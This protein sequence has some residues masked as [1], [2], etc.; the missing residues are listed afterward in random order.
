MAELQ[1]QL[2]RIDL[3]GGLD[4]KSDER[5]VLATKLLGLQNASF[6]KNGSLQRRDGWGN[7][8]PTL[9]TGPA[10]D[11]IAYNNELL[12]VDGAANLQSYSPNGQ[13]WLSRGALSPCSIKKDEI[14]RSTGYQNYIDSATGAGYTIFA[15]QD[16]TAAGSVTGVNVS[17]RDETSGTLVVNNQQVYAS[18]TAYAP[19]VCYANG[20]F[21]IMCADGGVIHGVINQ[22]GTTTFS[23]SSIVGS[24]NSTYPHYDVCVVDNWIAIV[25]ASSTYGVGLWVWDPTS[26]AV[27]LG[28]V[29]VVASGTIAASSITCIGVGEFSDGTHVG[30]V[31]GQGGGTYTCVF[32]VASNGT[33][34]APG[35]VTS[36]SGITGGGGCDSAGLCQN[37][38]LLQIVVGQNPLT[39]G[40]NFAH[41]FTL[42]LSTANAQGT[43]SA[44]QNSTSNGSQSMLGPVMAGK[45]F[46]WAAQ[47]RVFV[48]CLM[49]SALQAQLVLIDNLGNVVAR[50]LYGSYYAAGAGI[51]PEF[52][53]SVPLLG[54]GVG[55]SAIFSI[56]APEAG[57]LALNGSTGKQITQQGICRIQA[58]F[59]RSSGSV[60]LYHA[61]TAKNVYFSGGVMQMYDGA[62]VTEAGFLYYPE[63]VALSTAGSGL[64][65]VYS[66]AVTYEWID[67][68]GQRHQSAPSVAQQITLTNQSVVV[69]VPTL[70]LGARKNG[71]TIV[72]WRTIN[73]GQTYF[74]QTLVSAPVANAT[75][76]S[77]VVI[78]DNTSDANLST[79]EVLYT[80]A[81]A[82][83]ND[84][85]S[86]CRA[87]WVFQNR[88]FFSTEDP[89]EYRFSQLPIKSQGLMFSQLMSGYIPDGFGELTA[90]GVLDDKCVLFTATNKFWFDGQGPDITGNGATYPYPPLP[91]PSDTGCVDQRTV[92]TMPDI[93]I[94]DGEGQEGPTQVAQPGGLAYQTRHGLML[95]TRML[96]DDYF[97]LHA[98]GIVLGSTITSAVVLQDKQQ[99][100]FAIPSSGTVLVFDY[101]YRQWSTFTNY[102]ADT[103]CIWQGF[104]TFTKGTGLEQEFVGTPYDQGN[105]PIQVQFQTAWIALNT[106]LGYQRVRRFL[107]VGSY[108]ATSNMTIQC[109]VNFDSTIVGTA[110]GQTANMQTPAGNA[111]MLRW[112]LPDGVQKCNAVRFIVTDVPPNG[113]LLGGAGFSSMTLQVG[114][115]KGTAK[116]NANQS[117]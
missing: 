117:F 106:L 43:V 52:L 30:V 35:S 12:A 112:H 27:I 36:I 88:I 61:Q 50:A 82:L 20:Y 83:I 76:S 79:R 53:A 25:E 100:R 2:V 21:G 115:K 80:Q 31:I 46:L 96:Q 92:C 64:T 48:P 40:G 65:G 73:N 34:T 18:T 63:G 109:C 70:Q 94:E 55:G 10:S 11:L 101:L 87:I 62:A 4:S 102:Q 51:T 45:P 90:G 38:S 19:R 33:Y 7:V 13:L 69:T 75:G 104:Y 103:A 60:P 14:R 86:S 56:A 59:G 107:L 89:R 91:L 49:W 78:T 26:L 22:V 5:L 110:T 68:N 95:L 39:R 113:S 108:A 6:V 97:G 116:L 9:G 1:K 74:R 66:V 54:V 77:T 23:A 81:G 29:Q 17:I 71:T 67:N 42:T 8:G 3:T 72:V 114:V 44:F 47:S 58:T 24:Y 28:E 16:L 85:L 93:R 105:A 32:N 41:L 98:E 84:G 37:G 15:W 111:Y 57:Q 99:I